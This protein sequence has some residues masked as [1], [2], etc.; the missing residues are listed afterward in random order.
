MNDTIQ[1]FIAYD[2]GSFQV[3]F[4]RFFFSTV[5][6][7]PFIIYFGANTIKTFYPCLQI[8]RGVL[9]FVGIGAWIY[10]LNIVP[11]ST[12]TIMSFSVPIFVLFLAIFF[13]DE[14]IQTIIKTI[15]SYINRIV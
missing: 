1:K 3:T 4:L 15:G 12:A 6:L 11:I 2:L 13:L 10:G 8:L 14:K 7:I 5:T 9:L